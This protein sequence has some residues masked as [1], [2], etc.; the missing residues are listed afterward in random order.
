M[1][2]HLNISQFNFTSVESVKIVKI[3]QTIETEKKANPKSQ[4]QSVTDN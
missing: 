4:F 1:R 2:F 3:V